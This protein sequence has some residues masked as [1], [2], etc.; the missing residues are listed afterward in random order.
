VQVHEEIGLGGVFQRMVYHLLGPYQVT[1]AIEGDRESACQ[2]AM[3][4]RASGGTGDRATQ[5][6]GGIRARRRSS[7]RYSL[8]SEVVRSRGRSVAGGAIALRAEV[9]PMISRTYQRRTNMYWTA[10]GLAR[11]SWS[12]NPLE[13]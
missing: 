3:P 13:L 5:T 6:I 1:N 9:G 2:P 10:H 8:F 12:V 4:G 11:F 7:F